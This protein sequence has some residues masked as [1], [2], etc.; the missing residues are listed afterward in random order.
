MKID[1]EVLPISDSNVTEKSVFVLSKDPEEVVGLESVR[2]W[3]MKNLKTGFQNAICSGPIL[4]YPILNSKFVLHSIDI[5]RGTSETLIASAMEEA[6]KKVMEESGARL[7]EPVMKLEISV[8][9]ELTSLLVQDILKKRG[10]LDGSEEH[11]EIAELTAFAPLA[12]LRGY[13]S[14]VRILTSGKAFFGMEF[15]HY[16]L[17]D[18]FDQNK[19]IEDVTGFAP[20]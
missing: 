20:S 13:S 1:L 16:Q 11:D 5:A 4:G 3:Q 12:E 15:S 17:M 9:K 10:I 7:L 2:K 18:V 19:A 6:I 14:H 8:E